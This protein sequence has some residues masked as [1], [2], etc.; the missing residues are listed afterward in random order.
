MTPKNKN[1]WSARGKLNAGDSILDKFFFIFLIL[2]ATGLFRFIAPVLGV[3][4]KYVS[5][6][7]LLFN[8][9]YLVARSKHVFPFLLHGW[10]TPLLAFMLLIWPFLTILYAPAFDLRE[11]GLQLYF[12]TLF[13]ATVIYIRL[14]GLTAMYHMLTLSLVITVIGMSLSMMAPQ[15]FEPV[16]NLANTRAVQ[17][18][19]PIGFFMQPN[20]LVLS[21]CLLFVAWFALSPRKTVIKETA[22]V[23]VF[24]GLVLLTGS[25]AG[26]LV[27]AGIVSIL[28][29]H[30]WPKRILQG[31][32]IITGTLVVVCVAIGVIGL[33]I[34]LTSISGE[35]VR[36]SNFDLLARIES[37]A[38]F[39]FVQ[40]DNIT[41]DKS[42]KQRFSAQAKYMEYI[43]QK[44]ILGYGFHS[45]LYYRKKEERFSLSAH[46]QAL[47]Y[48]FE[49]G[50]F[51]PA[52]LFFLMASF[53]WKRGRRFI[54]HNLNTNCISQFVAVILVLFVYTSVMEHRVFYIVLGLFWAILQYQK[55]LFAQRKL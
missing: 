53:Y 5:L 15:L 18:G 45:S 9:L 24:L 40:G 35:A 3:R 6:A 17:Q 36:Y 1:T 27:G 20:R 28:L 55:P 26:V 47:T 16:A 32:L 7:I 2:N 39:K 49:Y 10:R 4:I 48:A 13:T 43:C 29:F 25:R 21:L 37:I 41:D 44:P 52:V 19:R 54:Q 12:F 14:N 11:V 33:R 30:N 42:L 31:R 50:V 34:Y 23:I 8:C 46:S 38:S 51:Y 22:A